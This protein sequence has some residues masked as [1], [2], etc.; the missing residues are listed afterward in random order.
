[1]DKTET[2]FQKYTGIRNVLKKGLNYLKRSTIRENLDY[3]SVTS[4]TNN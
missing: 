2:V 4:Y 3:H 1:M